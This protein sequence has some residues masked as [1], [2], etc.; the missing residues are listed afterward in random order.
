[1]EKFTC[2]L[3]TK[4]SLT[5]LLESFEFKPTEKELFLKSINKTESIIKLIKD[6]LLEDNATKESF[7]AILNIKNLQLDY[8]NEMIAFFVE[9]K[10]YLC[11][12]DVP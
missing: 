10:Y 5:D 11:P 6:V 9:K 4:Y 12:Q 8:Q 3:K 1:M 7:N 2:R